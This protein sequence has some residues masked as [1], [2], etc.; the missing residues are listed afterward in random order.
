MRCTRP[1]AVAT[2]LQKHQDR[3]GSPCCTLRGSYFFRDL[4]EPLAILCS[5]AFLVGCYQTAL[6]VSTW[7]DLAEVVFAWLCS[8]YQQA[9]ETMQFALLAA[10][11]CEPSSHM[12]LAA[13][14]CCQHVPTLLRHAY[15]AGRLI[16]TLGS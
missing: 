13:E 4:L 6:L 11:L 10:S 12:R 16:S 3:M 14:I 15:R 5:I 7:T 9:A 1:T 8:V 2:Q